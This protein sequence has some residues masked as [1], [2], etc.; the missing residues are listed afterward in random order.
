VTH[1]RALRPMGLLEIIDQ[2]FRLYRANFWLFFGIAAVGYVPLALLGAAS[3]SLSLVARLI[4]YPVSLVVSAALTKA[5]SD[6]YMG[7]TSSMGRA[8]AFIGERLLALMLTIV[9]TYLFVAAGLLLFVVGFIILAFWA[10]F[11]TQVFV[12][13]DKRYASAIWRSGF[14]ISQGVWAE[15][16]VLGLM[17]GILAVLVELPAVFLAGALGG[18][19]SSLWAVHGLAAGLTQSL[20]APIT[21]VA[22]IL[23]YYDSR[24]RKEGFDL[25]VLARELGKQLPPSPSPPQ[26]TQ[27]PNAATG[28]ANHVPTPPADSPGGSSEATP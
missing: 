17:T 2:T 13:E 6:R 9:I 24:I 23:L 15:L 27:P 28:Q 12:I 25:E 14:L 21:L 8:Y 10:A 18:P 16:F 1:T 3:V 26:P 22:T 5:V 11:V 7:D 4:M 20:A 19:G